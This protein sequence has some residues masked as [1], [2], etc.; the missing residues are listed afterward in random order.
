[1]NSVTSTV[2]FYIRGSAVSM[3]P[4]ASSRISNSAFVDILGHN[5]PGDLIE[6]GVGRGGRALHLSERL[7]QLRFWRPHP[8][9]PGTAEMNR[10]ISNDHRWMFIYWLK[11]MVA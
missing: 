11:L 5:I 2:S 10:K 7:S 4:L 8:S 3:T 1:L 6:A 9:P